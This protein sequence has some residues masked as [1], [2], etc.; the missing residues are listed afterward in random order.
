MSGGAGNDVISGGTDAIGDSLN[1]GDGNDSVTGAGGNDSLAGGNGA[2]TINGGV[3]NDTINVGGD[4]TTD[5]IQVSGVSG[6][7]QIVGF[8][9][10]GG[11]QDYIDIPAGDTYGTTQDG[12]NVIVDLGSGDS[13][14]I[15]GVTE[16]QIS[17]NIG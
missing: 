8:D 15:V 4:D 16:Q 5:T 9:V 11:T 1:G 2:D 3:G 10:T 13:L 17:D 6:D 14:T 7:D 12:G